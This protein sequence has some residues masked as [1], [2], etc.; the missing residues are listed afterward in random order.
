ML[1]ACHGRIQTQCAT[2]RRLVPHLLGRGADEEGRTTAVRLVRY[3]DTSALHHHADEEDDL[4]PALIE[5]MAGSD[6]ICLREMIDGLKADHRALEACWRHLRGILEKVAAGECVPLLT[7]DVEA[8]AGRY[9][10][11]IEREERELLPMAAR[12]L[13]DEDLAGVG[14]A[15]RERRGIR[16]I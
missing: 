8:L 14:R 15:M 1:S 3:F 12:L 5:S 4:F 13:S 16:A 11:H 2:L 10:R 7:N 9:E 6:A